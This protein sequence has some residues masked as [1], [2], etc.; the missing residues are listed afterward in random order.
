VS[1]QYLRQ[2]KEIATEIGQKIIE[3]ILEVQKTEEQVQV[4]PK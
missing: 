1:E 2:H 3:Q 4:D